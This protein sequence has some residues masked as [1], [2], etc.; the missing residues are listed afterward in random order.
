MEAYDDTVRQAFAALRDS[1]VRVVRGVADVVEAKAEFFSPA[2]VA[3]R[4]HLDGGGE[5]TWLASVTALSAECACTEFADMT[6]FEGTK[7]ERLA[8]AARAA[9][10]G[11]LQP[12]QPPTE[13][14]LGD[15]I[16]FQPTLAPH[17]APPHA[18]GHVGTHG[19]SRRASSTAHVPTRRLLFCAWRTHA[20][21]DILL[22]PLFATRR[23][24]NEYIWATAASGSGSRR[25]STKR[26]RRTEAQLLD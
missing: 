26:A 6:V 7:A 18:L 8:A 16:I 20:D 5:G 25:T 19:R 13:L 24:S 14:A 17:R 1:M 22:D 12:R 21:N 3:Q 10:E 23:G 4:W 11:T 15:T 9:D 2:R